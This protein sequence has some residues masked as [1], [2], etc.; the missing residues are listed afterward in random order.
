MAHRRAKPQVLP[1]SGVIEAVHSAGAYLAVA[2]APRGDYP[3]GNEGQ[4]HIIK[5]GEERRTRGDER[6][7][8]GG[9]QAQQQA[10]ARRSGCG[11][12][13]AAARPVKRTRK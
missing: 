10:A 7:G 8:E 3:S 9:L 1:F 6:A 13:P 11:G 2:V 12:G 5:F 4:I